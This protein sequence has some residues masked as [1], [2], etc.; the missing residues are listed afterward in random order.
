MVDQLAAEGLPHDLTTAIGE[1]LI[2]RLIALIVLLL[3]VLVVVV[4][5]E[6]GGAAG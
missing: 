1:G 6:R 4:L 5:Q 2:I 3:A